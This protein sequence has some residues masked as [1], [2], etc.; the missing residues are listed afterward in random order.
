M[1][2][3]VSLLSCLRLLARLRLLSR[4]RLFQTD[5]PRSVREQWEI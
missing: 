4:V 3:S 5:L 2:R 1:R